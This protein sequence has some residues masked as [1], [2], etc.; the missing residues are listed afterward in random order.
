[1]ADGEIYT[2][3]SYGMVRFSRSQGG[4]FTLFG[5]SVQHNHTISLVICEAERKRN[6]HCDWYHAKQELIEI[7]M[8]PVQFAELVSSLN[9]GDGV[10]CT[11]ERVVGDEF[12][13]KT[14]RFRPSPPQEH[15]R[16][17]FENE[18]KDDIKEVAA[19]S[20]KLAATINSV[21]AKKTLTQ[22]DRKDV[23]KMLSML[24][25]HI[26]SNMPFV[27]TQFNEQIERTVVE[28]KGEIDA[29]MTHLLVRLGTEKLQEMIGGPDASK[30]LGIEGPSEVEGE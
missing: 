5:S 12:N 11:I 10:P 15:K 30:A 14:R 17:E 13:N 26:E 6:L 1:M 2:H 22:A 25:Q 8:S 18:F 28:A 20:K 7:R 29:A 4:G 19:R 24:L 21:L 23:A 27:L 3:P 16:A 9:C